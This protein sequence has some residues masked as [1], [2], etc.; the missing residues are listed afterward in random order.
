MWQG[1]KTALRRTAKGFARDQGLGQEVVYKRVTGV[2]YDA[3]SQTAIPAYAETILRSIVGRITNVSGESERAALGKA[4]RVF[5]ILGQ[6][7]AEEPRPGDLI[8]V[9][10]ESYRVW[11]IETDSAGIRYRIEA[12]RQ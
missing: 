4:V 12:L 10:A 3:A 2:A 11:K 9:G 8:E 1:V 7:L 5:S 6:D